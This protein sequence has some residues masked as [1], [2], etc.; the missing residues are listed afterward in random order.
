MKGKKF[1]VALIYIFVAYGITQ[2][3]VWA[4]ENP[5]DS[6]QF[7]YVEAMESQGAFGLETPTLYPNITVGNSFGREINISRYPD[8]MTGV[9][10]PE[11]RRQHPAWGQ[12]VPSHHYSFPSNRMKTWELCQIARDKNIKD[13]SIICKG[14]SESPDKLK[15]ECFISTHVGGNDMQEYEKKMWGGKFSFSSRANYF[16]RGRYNALKSVAVRQDIY[17]PAIRRAVNQIVAYETMDPES[18]QA[19]ISRDLEYLAEFHGTD[20]ITISPALNACLGKMPF[21]DFK[22]WVAWDKAQF[23]DTPISRRTVDQIAKS[24][25]YFIIYILPFLL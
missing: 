25:I 24:V 14:D 13:L 23:P 15:S 20:D 11:H 16:D 22:K 18:P 9:I 17:G 12:D 2:G 19:R 8:M 5:C 6:V 1:V 10:L 3:L 4:D 7:H 21:E